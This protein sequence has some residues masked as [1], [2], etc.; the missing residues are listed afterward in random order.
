MSDV[1][2]EDM[3]VQFDHDKRRIF[4]VQSGLLDKNG[5]LQSYRLILNN[6][7]FSADYDTLAD[8]RKI[9]EVQLGP[10]D[11]REILAETKEFD[12]R[13]GR[14]ALVVGDDIGRLLLARLFCEFSALLSS[15][16]IRW[17]PFRTVFEAEQWLDSAR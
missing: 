7:E 6:A 9:S 11:F 15:A 1:F 2:P 13:T 5:V 4:F 17:R 8:Y 3:S 10:R 14:G 16:K 12:V